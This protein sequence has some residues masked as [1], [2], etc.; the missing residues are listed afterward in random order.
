MKLNCN[1]F[2]MMYKTGD[3]SN[4]ILL[5]VRDPGECAGGVLKGSM[6][7]PIEEL[8]AR[9]H[10]IPKDKEVFI[11]CRAGGRAERAEMFLIHKGIKSTRFANP[12][13][14]DELKNLF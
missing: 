10:E 13:G 6:N 4:K 7:I 8:E 3:R 11:Y 2:A 14:Y 12:G 9:F 5:D 1:E